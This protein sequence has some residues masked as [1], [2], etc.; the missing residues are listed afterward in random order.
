MSET[1]LMN[2]EWYG[3]P[4][5]AH[6]TTP[7][8]TAAELVLL[9]KEVHEL[10]YTSS[11]AYPPDA[12]S[13]TFWIKNGHSVIWNEVPA[14]YYS[15][16]VAICYKDNL[17]YSGGPAYRTYVVMDYV[18]GKTASQLLQ[19]AADDEEAKDRIYEQV[20]FAL[21]ELNRIPVPEGSRPAAVNGGKIRHDLFEFTVASRPYRNVTELED[22]LNV[23]LSMT[24]AKR[25][26]EKL[27]Q[28]PM[29][30]CYSDV[31]LG[32]FI[33]DD[34]GGIVVVD[35][36]DASILP[37]SF[38]R[39][40]IAGA[41]DKIDRDIRDMVVVPKTE[42]IDN[43]SALFD[44]ARPMVNGAGSFA[45]AGRRLLGNY[46]TEN[47]PDQVHKL[48]TDAQSQP[49]IF[50]LELARP[51]PHP[52]FGEPPPIFTG[53]PFT[54][55]PPPLPPLPSFTGPPTLTGPFPPVTPRPP[56][57]KASLNFSNGHG[58]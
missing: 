34:D 13:P 44:V 38:S 7:L 6:I 14:A 46:D 56:P 23:F 47:E 19:D 31:W 17:K 26:V 15:C 16:R 30:F 18:Q 27:A 21:S 11:L 57:N 58:I 40:S 29:V 10:G 24:K 52:T 3:S 4:V 49:V 50:A 54:E 8:P 53:Y 28:E 45:K 51:S 12:K 48:V 42:G 32:N 35:F 55:L 2:R 36:E 22:H 1:V 20:A 33:I 43:T 9:C 25:R 37:S 41:W 39:F 5:P